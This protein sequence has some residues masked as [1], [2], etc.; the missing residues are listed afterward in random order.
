VQGFM[1]LEHLQ[2]LAKFGLPNLEFWQV[3]K[4]DGK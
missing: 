4:I 1:I 2:Q 3:A